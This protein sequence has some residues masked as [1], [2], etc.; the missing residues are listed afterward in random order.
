MAWIQPS[1]ILLDKS[2]MS[3]WKFLSIGVEYFQVSVLFIVHYPL[4][5]FQGENPE[6][7]HVSCFV[8]EL[9]EVFATLML[10]F[11]S[12]PE[13]SDRLSLDPFFFCRKK[14]TDISEQDCESISQQPVIPEHIHANQNCLVFMSWYTRAADVYVEYCVKLN[15][16]KH[17]Q[18]FQNVRLSI[19]SIS[20][21]KKTRIQIW[22]CYFSGLRYLI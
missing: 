14:N 10:L 17:F 15:K 13:L 4:L 2:S 16:N 7:G 11:V 3:V 21:R 22:F 20:C 1:Q 12:C 18:C 6:S 9:C 8:R 19:E 5:T